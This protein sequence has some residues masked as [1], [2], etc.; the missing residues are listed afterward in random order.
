MKKIFMVA[1]AAML[2]TWSAMAA[3]VKI[4][5]TASP[6]TLKDL[7]GTDTMV[8][9]VLKESG[10]KDSNLK[11]VEVLPNSI[12]VQTEKGEI[13]P[14][15]LEMLEEIQ[16]QGGQVE[17]KRFKAEDI[18]VLRPE[19]QRVVER[20]M[21]RA[22]EIFAGASD[23]QELK[24]QAAVLM[25]LNKDAEATKYL[26]QLAETNDIAVQLTASR[27]L[28]LV[29]EPVSETLLRQGLESGNRQARAL[30]ASL[31]G[32][33]NYTAGIPLLGPLFNDRAVELSAPAARA[34]ARLGDRACVPRLMAMLEESNEVK[35]EAAVFA[36]SRLGG[37]DIMQDM[38][39]QLGDTEG[40]IRY[41]ALRVLYRMKAPGVNELISKVF[42]DYPTLA[43]RAALVLARD[44]DW[45]ATQFLRSR[46]TRREDPTDANLMYRAEAAAA[47][48]VNGDPSTLAVF[49]E[50][51]RSNSTKAKQKVFEMFTDIGS[52]R[53]I[54]ILQPS[55]ENVD[56]H[57]SLDACQ[58]VA[59]LALP[60]FRA[61]VMEMRSEQ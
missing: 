9:V 46:L 14:Y 44:G 42:K 30:A 8:T 31:A 24:M 34:L 56:K 27:A 57:M 43:P 53:L 19:Q 54:P 58:T 28:Y 47:L 5:G 21:S 12:N 29:G 26:K 25:A 16:V 49:Q 48:L 6:T 35:G 20:A 17:G 3:D 11:V 36:L 61:R 22:A 7:V 39:A 38:K 4:T 55:I 51:L 13:V 33:N 45:E 18:Q 60:A 2:A 15:L 32:L 52:V 40:I 50:I 37:D 59:T 23:D 41:R 10:A 1:A